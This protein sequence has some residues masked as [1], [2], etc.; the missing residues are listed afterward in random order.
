MPFNKQEQE[1]INFGKENGKSSKDIINA[2]SKFRASEK[3]KPEQK[4]NIFQKTGSRIKETF[5]DVVQTGKNIGSRFTEGADKI[6]E[7]Q[8]AGQRGEQ[9]KAS[10]ALQTFGAGAGAVSQSVGDVFTGGIKATL[11]QKN[12]EAFKGKVT[13]VVSKVMKNPAIDTVTKQY[14]KAYQES[15]PEVQRNLEGIFNIAMLGLDVY[16]SGLAKKG[17][18]ASKNVIKKGLGKTDD[19]LRSAE[20]QLLAKSDDITGAVKKAGQVITGKQP[21]PIEAVGQVLQGKPSDIK[22]GVRGLALLDT[23]KI[24]TQKELFNAIIDK[25]KVLAKQVDADLAV[26]KTRRLLKDLKTV[27]KTVSGKAIKSNPV[28]RALTHL[29]ELY[30]KIG[31]DLKAANVDEL[32]KSAKKEGLTNFDINEI[33]KTYG[34]EFSSKAFSKIGDPLTSVNAKLFENTRKKLK[35]LARQGMKGES[36]KAADLAMSNLYNVRR[37]VEKNVIAVNKLR[38]KIRNRGLFESVGN[39][40]SKY[41]NTLTGGGVR[42]FITG[43]VPSGKGLKILNSLDLEKVLKGNLKIIQDAIQS[44]SDKEI[45]KILKNLK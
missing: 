26:D 25:T 3:T 32:I 9:G 31:D 28:D 6:A 11:S 24:K 27:S 10:T 13:N 45:I 4:Q 1:I 30:L 38:Q 35:D 17:V 5:Q 40:I 18:T 7:I 44:K 43:L 39:E 36:A 15:S 22:S 20:K 2:I 8:S 42:G 14:I 21:T 12:E 19:I 23:S 34:I 16:G 29:K 41:A 33:A 37:L